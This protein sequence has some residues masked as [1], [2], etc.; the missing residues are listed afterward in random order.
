MPETNVSL[1][2]P[3]LAVTD[4]E[5][6]GLLRDANAEFL[7]GLERGASFQRLERVRR[8][9]TVRSRLFGATE[10]ALAS[11]LLASLL[12]PKV[13]EPARF[14]VEAEP[15]RASPLISS[16]AAAAV[17]RPIEPSSP[18][19]ALE[20]KGPP[21]GKAQA[22]DPTE[23]ACQALSARGKTE[24]AI[25]C[26]RALGRENG[27]VAD[28]ALYNAARLELDKR[29][30]AQGALALLDEHRRRF[31]ASSLATEREWL[32]VRS[33]RAS[34]RPDD[35]LRASEG[36]LAMPAGALLSADL[37]ELRAGIAE[38]RG[39]CAA[40]ASELLALIDEPGKRGDEAEF[41]RA[42]CLEKLG[43]AD[44]RA[45]YVHYLARSEARHL[46]EAGT[47]LGL[48]RP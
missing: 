41:S 10:L 8:R 30:D 22:P 9:R 47:R 46:A 18:E 5:L 1:L 11:V 35:A 42:R 6:G 37:H 28:V 48:L 27:I 3:R 23:S 38:E 2:P 19:R 34:G 45:A 13:P 39:D 15:A 12:R 40:A 25:E 21:P 20:R 17:R 33:L 32:R 31:P 43:R 7:Q 44:A 14:A 4:D 24:R 26:Y 36:L 16:S 29:A